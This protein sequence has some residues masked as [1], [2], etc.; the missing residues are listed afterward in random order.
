MGRGRD[1]IRMNGD[2]QIRPRL[3]GDADALVEGH[4]HVM[5]A[6]QGNAVA[7]RALEL[8]PQTF[9]KAEY[10]V[11]LVC[12]SRG[13]GAWINAAMTGID[14]DERPLIGRAHR[15]LGT[16]GPRLLW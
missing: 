5:I 1:R 15:E 8:P 10:D 14:H 7:A 16:R 3:A 9:G 2:Q 13:D 11:L 6:R 4:E 12:A